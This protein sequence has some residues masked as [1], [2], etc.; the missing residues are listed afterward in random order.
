MEKLHIER[1]LEENHWNIK[2]AAQVLEIDRQT[3]YNKIERYKI[4]KRG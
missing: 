3:L 4:E 1:I 2:R